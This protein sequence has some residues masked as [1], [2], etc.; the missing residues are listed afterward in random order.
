MSRNRKPRT[1]L[2][3]VLSILLGLLALVFTFH[4]FSFS[5]VSHR[6]FAKRVQHAVYQ[7]DDH[8]QQAKT[9]LFQSFERWNDVGI[10]PVEQVSLPKD[11]SLFVY[12]HDTLVY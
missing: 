5:E 9:D 4:L 11:V 7:I 3:W 1:T 8:I 10:L 2:K 12:H 6:L